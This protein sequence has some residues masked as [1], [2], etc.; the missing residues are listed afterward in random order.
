M[1]KEQTELAAKI[2][3]SL[4]KLNPNDEMMRVSP[5]KP[6]VAEVAPRWKVME[7]EVLKIYQVLQAIH[8]VTEGKN[9]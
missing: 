3:C 8:Y 1:D 2:L 4:R 6:N 5:S 7:D 9:L